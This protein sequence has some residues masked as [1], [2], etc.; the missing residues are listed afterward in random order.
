MMYASVNGNIFPANEAVLQVNDMSIQRGYGVFD[1]F[2]VVNGRPVFLEDHL[3]RLYRSMNALHLSIP[4]DRTSLQHDIEALI[5]RNALPE[6]GV[7]ITITGGYAPDGYSVTEPNR[8][9]T[10]QPLQLSRTISPGITLMTYEHQRQM[11]DVKTIDYLMPVSLQGF[12]KSKKAQDILYHANGIISEC[13]R[14][15]FFIVNKEGVLQ[16][17][18]SNILEGVTRK[19]ILEIAAIHELPVEAT[20][21]TLD[22]VFNA[23]E[24]FIASTTKHVLPVWQIDGRQIGNGTTGK[25]TAQLSESLI[26]LVFSH[27][28]LR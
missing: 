15:N 14:A 16:T 8:I 13:P 26:R 21:L 2:K 24:A 5:K 6:C 20:I 27:S 1:F 10:M 28:T 4:E 11:P 19:K 3:D 18:V 25:V 22:D 23:E 12:L 17:S 9:I 7:R